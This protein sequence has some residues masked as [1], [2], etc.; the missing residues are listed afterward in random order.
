MV[1]EKIQELL[2][3]Q[4]NIDKATITRETNII[5]DLKADSLDVVEMLITLE[6]EFG[7]SV[8]DED[9]KSLTTI[10]DLVNYVESKTEQ[11]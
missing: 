10:G 11:K 7:I 8:P 2:S 6:D 4:L 5:D 3:E 9:A 1:F